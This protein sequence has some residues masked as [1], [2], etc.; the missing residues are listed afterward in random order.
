MTSALEI[1]KYQITVN[2]IARGLHL[3]D[4]FP[5]SVGKEKAEKL[6]TKYA[7]QPYIDG[8]IRIGFNVS[9]TVSQFHYYYNYYHNNIFL[10]FYDI[11]LFTYL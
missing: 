9:L 3:N 7:S 2:V 4:E 6:V 8:T 5:A 10:L 1:G 11:I